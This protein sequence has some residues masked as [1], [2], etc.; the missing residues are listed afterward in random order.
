MNNLMYTPQ[1]LQQ[2]SQL[3]LGMFMQGLGQLEQ[4]KQNDQATLANVMAE[5]ERAAQTHGLNMR[6]G[7]ATLEGTMLGN[8]KARMT[9][10]STAATLPSDIQAKIF[11]NTAKMDESQFN[12]WS[13]KV[14]RGVAEGDPRMKAIWEQ[15]PDIQMKRQELAQA[16]EIERM[17]DAT[18]R[19]KADQQAASVRYT[20]DQA[21]ARSTA[22]KAGGPRIPRSPR[23]LYS[24]YQFEAN[25]PERTP[26]QRQEMQM[27]ADRE[28]E[29]IVQEQI[30][31]AQAAGAGK[32]DVAGMTQG[33]IPTRP[34]PQASDI[35]PNRQPQPTP[36]PTQ[37]YSVGQVYPG[38]TGKYK[39]KGGDPTNKANWEKVE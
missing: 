6:Q 20:A 38:S 9:N 8:Q 28:L 5:R 23:E 24:M 26:E 12:M 14:Q 25:N 7:E 37:Q 35:L 16:A 15:M 22:G 1:N 17:K 4:F 27:L 19:Y 21:T 30:L 32:P 34:M 18:D 39:Y 29:K 33:S 2:V 36:Q 13:R 11:E 31:K 10:E 3:P